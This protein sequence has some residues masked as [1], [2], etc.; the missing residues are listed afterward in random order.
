MRFLLGISRAI[1]AATEAV[2]QVVVWLVLL[3]TLLSAGNA[4]MRYLFHY[5]SNAYL[6]AQWYLFSLIFLWGAGWTLKHRGHVRVDV[7]YS[8]LPRKG[9]LWIDLLGTIFFLMPMVVLILVLSWPIVAESVRIQE[10]SP[11]AGGLPRWPIKLALVIGFVLLGLQGI[12]EIIKI[13]LAL[14]GKIEIKEESQ[15]EVV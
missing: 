10:M 12:S 11:D 9:Q 1:D 6:E 14:A 7:L 13:S 3:V 5:S 8:R 2:G 15:E 4:L